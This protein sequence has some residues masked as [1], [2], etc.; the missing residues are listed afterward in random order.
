MNF[1]DQNKLTNTIETPNPE[2]IIQPDQVIEKPKVLEAPDDPEA[3]TEYQARNSEV[4]EQI[5]ETQKNKEELKNQIQEVRNNLGLPEEESTPSID[6]LNSKLETL[7]IKQIEASANYP[8]DWTLLLR[9][10]MLDPINKEKFIATR[11]DAMPNMKP[12]EAPSKPTDG[13][14]LIR[15]KEYQGYYQKQIDE[16]DTNINRIFDRTYIGKSSKYDKQPHNLGKG[17]IGFE[18][19]IFTDGEK[20]DGTNL[21]NREKNIIESHEKG[22]G[23]RDFVSEDRRDFTQSIDL[24][25]IRKKESET[26][27]RESGYM[28]QADEIAERMAQLKNYFGFKAGDIFTKEHLEYAKQHYVKNIGLDNNM[29]TFF[30]AITDNTIDTFLQTINKYPL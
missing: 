8:G 17:E 6:T 18:G 21:S 16:Y 28:K 4:Q 19:A 5:E 25:V 27:I 24:E 30:D 20:R 12:G 11:T 9:D 7:R 2:V 23:L 29:T 13:I 22:H 1:E 14:S 3:V 15:E 26:G 10:R